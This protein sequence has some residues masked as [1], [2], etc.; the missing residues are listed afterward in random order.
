[1]TS[2]S[3]EVPSVTAPSTTTVSEEARR[4]MLNLRN[5]DRDLALEPGSL[6]YFQQ[7]AKDW[8]ALLRYIALK[9]RDGER[10][11]A[12]RKIHAQLPEIARFT[13]VPID[14]ARRLHGVIEMLSAIDTS[15]AQTKEK[16][17]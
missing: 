13:G 1:M 4:L 7:N 15:I 9:E 16:P 2:H 10:V 12:M 5:S 17:E 11:E 8:D 6:A 14:A 3:P